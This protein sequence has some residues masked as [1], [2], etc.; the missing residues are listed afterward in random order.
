M[1]SGSNFIRQIIDTDLEEA[2]AFAADA[3]AFAQSAWIIRLGPPFRVNGG[4]AT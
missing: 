1:P 3:L 2:I 4:G